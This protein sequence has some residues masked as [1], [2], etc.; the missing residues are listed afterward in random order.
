MTDYQSLMASIATKARAAAR[1]LAAADDAAKAKALTAAAQALRDQS[2]D[3]LAANAIDLAA[4]TNAG[5]S[6]AMLD[7]L[8]LDDARV[9]AMAAKLAV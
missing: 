9:A 2:A 7:R 8:K 6:P 1:Q 4:G 5:L 3:I